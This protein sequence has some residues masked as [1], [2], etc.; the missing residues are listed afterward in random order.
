MAPSAVP[1]RTCHVMR[2]SNSVRVNTV[3]ENRENH[4]LYLMAVATSEGIVFEPTDLF[5]SIM[6]RLASSGA[7]SRRNQHLGVSDV[8]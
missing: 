8:M 5:R 4:G 3:R 7:K 2:T 6:P 1:G